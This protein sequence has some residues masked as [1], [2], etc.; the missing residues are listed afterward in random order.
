[1]RCNR[2]GVS[3]GVLALAVLGWAPAGAC[4]GGLRAG[5]GGL[6][7]TT[8]RT[9]PGV[10]KVVAKRPPALLLAE[11]GTG[12]D[13][14]PDHFRGT[15]VGALVDCPDWRAEPNPVG[16]A[17]RRGANA[18]PPSTSA[19]WTGGYAALIRSGARG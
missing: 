8:V 1:M 19:L 7:V 15:A 3:A 16:K 2:R 10:K 13:V 6:G 5:A 9:G 17:P 18:A 14:A 11:D 4:A 12:C